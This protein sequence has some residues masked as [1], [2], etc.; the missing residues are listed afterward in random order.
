M[1]VWVL[2][3][4]DFKVNKN[5]FFVIQV[6]LLSYCSFFQL[7]I[8]AWFNFFETIFPLFFPRLLGYHHR[9]KDILLYREF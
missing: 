1:V 2:R 9:R 3:K 4:K 5:V 7:L 8:L 6:T